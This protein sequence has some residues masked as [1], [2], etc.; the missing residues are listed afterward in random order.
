[1]I[2]LDNA[3]TTFPKPPCV[4]DE[5]SKCLKKYC[6]NPGRSSHKLSVLSSEKIYDTRVLLGEIFDANPE[7]VIFTYNTT[8]AL[9]MAIKSNLKPSSHI[10]ISDIEHNSVL[11]PV[12]ESSV[13][14]ICSYDVFCTSG[15]SQDIIS[16]IRSK[17]KKNTSMLVCAHVSNIGSRTLP[18]KEIGQL[19]SENGIFFIVD[20]AQSAGIKNISVKDMNI[21][22]LC[23]PAHKGLYGPQGVGVIIYGSENIGKTLIEG[24]TGINSLDAEMPDFLPERYEAGTSST[25]C[26]V[27]LGAS[28]KWLKSIG[29]DNIRRHE[30]HLYTA[31]LD[32]L[33]ENT[34]ITVYRM[35][36]YA[37]NTLAFNIN[38][39]SS[40]TVAAELD[41]RD[42]CVRSG[43]HCSPMAHRVMKTGSG[44]AVRIGIGVF[45]KP[46]DIYA[47]Y[48]ALLDIIKNK[49]LVK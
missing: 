19:C 33:S 8:Y 24:G 10:L 2:Y 26:I 29:I 34:D 45:N 16:D 48:E 12:H 20:G 15:N 39:L 21:G 14:G 49:R 38:G 46:A 17:I 27:G 7:N 40:A 28:L 6:G 23:L 37:G 35:N 47:L 41:K 43:F 30:E 3:A 18:I 42:I 44:G 13:C 32:L 5:M 1:M 36:D 11:R 22:A 25:P 31:L 9:N 4:A